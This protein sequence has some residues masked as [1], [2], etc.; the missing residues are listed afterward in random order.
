MTVEARSSGRGAGRRSFKNRPV[1]HRPWAL[2]GVAVALIGLAALVWPH[3]SSSTTAPRVAPVTRPVV[4]PTA[5]AVSY[6]AFGALITADA[7]HDP[8][9]AYPHAQAYILQ[10]GTH[11]RLVV[12][13]GQAFPHSG[14]GASM[15]NSKP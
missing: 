9:Q 14:L 11:T 10:R 2:G 5:R 3:P 8:A 6:K 12:R 15:R 13:D 7:R 1:R 4:Y